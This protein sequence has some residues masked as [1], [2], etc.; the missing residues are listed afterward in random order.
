MRYRL[1]IFGRHTTEHRPFTAPK[2]LVEWLLD[3]DEILEVEVDEVR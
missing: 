1:S 2:D 3:Q